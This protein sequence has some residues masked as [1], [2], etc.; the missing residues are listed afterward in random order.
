MCL[1][2]GSGSL[3][4]S[5]ARQ[6]YVLAGIYALSQLRLLTDHFGIHHPESTIPNNGG[7]DDDDGDD[8]DVAC[9]GTSDAGD[10]LPGC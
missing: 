1:R 7:L 10:S 4:G 6:A 2:Q 5:E 3:L 9:R 8:D